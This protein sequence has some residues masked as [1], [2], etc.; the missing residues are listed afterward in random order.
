MGKSRSEMSRERRDQLEPGRFD[1]CVKQLKAM[2]YEVGTVD[3]RMITFT[4]KGQRIIFYPFTG[5]FTG[6][7]VKDGRGINNLLNQLKSG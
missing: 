4:H 2:G 3:T 1:F 5:W 7:T 6:K